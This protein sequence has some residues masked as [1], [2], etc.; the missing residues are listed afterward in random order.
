MDSLLYRQRYR[1]LQ[2]RLGAIADRVGLAQPSAPDLQAAFL[3][4]QQWFQQ[5]ILDDTGAEIPPAIAPE[6]QAYVVELNKQFRLLAVDVMFLQSS[7]QPQTR[8]Q[9]QAQIRDRLQRLQAY[10]K[11]VLT[12]EAETLGDEVE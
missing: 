10:C 5:A 2:E 6:V 1:A 9:R 3:G 7:R 4:A 12:L 8:L 11:G